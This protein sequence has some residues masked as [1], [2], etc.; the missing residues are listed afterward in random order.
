M[1][2][3]NMRSLL[4]IQLELNWH[5]PV[6]KLGVLFTPLLHATSKFETVIKVFCAS[7]RACRCQKI[8]WKEGWELYSV[9]KLLPIRKHKGTNWTRA[10][11]RLPI[12]SVDPV[13][14]VK[15]DSLFSLKKSLISPLACSET[16]AM[17]HD[18][19]RPIFP[20]MPSCLH[21]TPYLRT[22]S[23]VPRRFVPTFD[24]FV[25]NP[26]VDSY[27]TN[28]DTKCLNKHKHLFHFS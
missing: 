13:R 19:L 14:S 12:R 16:I 8:C 27:P 1:R 11:N 3:T 26:L 10:N 7:L 15:R 21:G 23:F 25:P 20:E 24:Q 6:I 18:V 22:R 5:S 9:E 2:C 17:R 28:Y 4:S